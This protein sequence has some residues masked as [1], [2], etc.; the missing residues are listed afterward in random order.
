MLRNQPWLLVVAGIVAAL[1]FIGLTVY[2][3]TAATDHPR[4]KHM[5]LFAI[6]AILSLLV[7]WFSYPKRTNSLHS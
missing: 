6:L 7:V 4:V 1:I 3:G 2:F 5:I